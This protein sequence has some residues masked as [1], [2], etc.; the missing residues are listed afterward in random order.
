MFRKGRPVQAGSRWN[1]RDASRDAT[2]TRFRLGNLSGASFVGLLG[3]S[4]ATTLLILGV[5]AWLVV[6]C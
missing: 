5:N 3:H 2:A 4:N 6:D 1:M